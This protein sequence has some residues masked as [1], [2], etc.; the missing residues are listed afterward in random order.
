MAANK[1]KKSA[2]VPQEKLSKSDPDFY[3]TI[4]RMAGQKLKKKRGKKYFS[5][6]AKKS[7]PR[8]EYKGGR[9]KKDALKNK[10]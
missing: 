1:P 3:S 6:L 5:E 8:T 9:P 7:H 2:R 4:A 10:P